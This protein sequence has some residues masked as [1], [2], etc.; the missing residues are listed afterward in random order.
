MKWKPLFL[1]HVF[2]FALAAQTLVNGAISRPGKRSPV[3]EDDLKLA[4]IQNMIKAD[5]PLT[6]GFVQLHR[7]GDEAAVILLKILG[8]TPSS[9]KFTDIQKRTVLEIINRA[10]EHPNSIANR[11]NVIPR[12]TN[13]LLNMLNNNTED[14]D[15]KAE[16]S[17][18]RDFAA[19]AASHRVY[20]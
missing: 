8:S 16:I 14:S 12:A 5:T 4:M 1:L 20:P 17:R 2:G 7:M 10:F 3:T 13:L 19:A 9:T 15:V 11:S 6:G 18:T